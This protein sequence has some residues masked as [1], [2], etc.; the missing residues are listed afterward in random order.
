MAVLY[1][2]KQ[3]KIK[4]LYNKVD[5][6]EPD[7]NEIESLIAHK[8][9]GKLIAME[10]QAF[11]T[12]ND[13]FEKL[14]AMINPLLLTKLTSFINELPKHLHSILSNLF[15]FDWDYNET[16]IMKFIN[17]IQNQQP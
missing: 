4:M 16:T 7:Y 3:M 9:V 14:S 1:M 15:N 10:A 13:N 6:I 11:S 17:Q 5:N 2:R 12:G 8:N